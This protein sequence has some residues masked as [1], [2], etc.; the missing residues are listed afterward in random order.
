[1]TTLPPS[2]ITSK[3]ES[4]RQTVVSA[5]ITEDLLQA[6]NVRLKVD[7]YQ[8]IGQLLRDY[9]TYKFPKY[10]K[11]EQVE[12]LLDR[13]K[14]RNIKD[15]FTGEVDSVTFYENV[16]KADFLNYLLKRYHLYDKH[17][18]DMFKYWEK[19][20]K[21][22][23]TKPEL[24]LTESPSVREWIT[25]AMK[26]FGEYW[27]LKFHDPEVR[28][29][30]DEI[31]RRYRMGKDI[32]RHS[33]AVLMA[34]K[35]QLQ[36][37]IPDLLEIAAGDLGL[38]MRMGLFTGLRQVELVYLHDTPVCDKPLCECE[39]LHPI[40]LP[41]HGLTWIVINRF[42]GQKYC[43]MTIAPTA[44]FNRF[45]ALQ[46]VKRE[47][48]ALC[49]QLLKS[50]TDNQVMFMTLRKIHYNVL[51]STMKKD[52]VQALQGRVSDVAAKHYTMY[53]QDEL[54]NNYREAWT[55]FGIEVSAAT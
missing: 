17:G 5:R 9:S 44:L 36:K 38:I 26:R 47:D 16:E 27:D 23:F 49:T 31:I 51:L 34:S 45:R 11:D 4:P 24:I 1:M 52:D 3:S 14:D 12:K 10:S 18:R 37:L 7:G 25:G 35:F 6:L 29:L 15:P 39:N 43:Y 20:C 53:L 54:A 48:E 42:V 19:W 8:N 21:V 41:H 22:F 33:K 50:R 40:D 2:Q 13:I 28:L 30:I 55:R 32:N 46:T